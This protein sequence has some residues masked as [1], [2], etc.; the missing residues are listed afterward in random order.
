MKFVPKIVKFLVHEARVRAGQV[1]VGVNPHGAVVYEGPSRLDPTKWVVV[2]VTGLGARA[3]SNVKTGRMVQTWILLRD[4]HPAEAVKAGPSAVRGNCGTCAFAARCYVRPDGPASVWKA[5]QGKA[6]VYL[7]G[8]VRPVVK[9][10]RPY[11]RL[12][13]YAAGLLTG[14]RPVRLGSYG[15]PG[16]VPVQ[17]WKDLLAGA[18]VAGTTRWTGYTHAWDVLPAEE[19]WES[20][21]MA[22]VETP[23]TYAKAVARGFRTFRVILNTE[24]RFREEVLCPASKEAGFKTTCAACGLCNGRKANDSRRNI[25]IVLHGSVP[26]VRAMRRI[27][28][29]L[30]AKEAFVLA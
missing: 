6:E 30:L 7:R 4:R 5:Y 10:F 17:V 25:A 11:R 26:T 15:D 20:L 14:G 22:S 8:G 27:I 1:K 3:S 21:L 29:D 13:P 12:S 23:G 19:G 16:A 28:E 9:Q 18:K 24:D 2:V